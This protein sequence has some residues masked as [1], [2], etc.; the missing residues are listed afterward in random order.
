MVIDGQERNIADEAYEV[1]RGLDEP[2]LDLEARA[3]SAYMGRTMDKAE[4]RSR[5]WRA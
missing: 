3:R 5:I 4:L 2:L 1:V